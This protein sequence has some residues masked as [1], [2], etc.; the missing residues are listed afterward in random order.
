[1]IYSPT[2]SP[3][4]LLFYPAALAVSLGERQ[5]LNFSCRAV[6]SDQEVSVEGNILS[7]VAKTLNNEFSAEPEVSSVPYFGPSLR[8]SEASGQSSTD[9]DDLWIWSSPINLLYLKM[10]LLIAGGWHRGF[11]KVSF[12]PNYSVIL[13]CSSVCI[14]I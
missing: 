7:L 6:W 8:L 5:M 3:V 9:Q 2:F 11:F 13:L 12:N 14:S 10:P 4:P 1:M